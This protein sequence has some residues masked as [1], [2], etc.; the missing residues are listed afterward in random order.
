MIFYFS[1]TGNTRL[2]ATLLAEALG[3]E[4]GLIFRTVPEEMFSK[5]RDLILMFPVYAWGVPP[6]MLDFADR[7]PEPVL[8][9]IRKGEI[10]LWCVATCGDETGMAVEMLKSLLRKKGVM[11]SGAWSVTA[12]NVYVLLPGFDV[13]PQ[14]VE[15]DKLHDIKPRVG[16]IAH[17]IRNFKD[18]DKP[19]EDVFRG[20]WPR[21]KTNLVFP[22]FKRWGINYRK[23]RWNKECIS[24]GRC[25][26][27]CPQDNIEMIGGHPRWGKECVSC[28]AC[29]HVCPR[30]AVEYGNITIGKGQYRRLLK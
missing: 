13:D 29:Y 24:C 9:K 28:L 15:M 5:D 1:G 2:A 12:P 18:G 26:E 21:I 11:L 4:T 17:H 19:I 7:I 10:R 16:E 8:E 30:H 20:P 14:N 3:T 25:A 27:V 23:W 6:V 22:L